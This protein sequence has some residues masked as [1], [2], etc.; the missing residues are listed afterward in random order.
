MDNEGDCLKNFGRWIT[1]TMFDSGKNGWEGNALRL[2]NSDL[3]EMFR[4]TLK[5]GNKDVKHLCLDYF[6]EEFAEC[7]TLVADAE[8]LHQEEVGWE[9]SVK[10]KNT[11]GVSEVITEGGAPDE[12]HLMWYA[13]MSSFTPFLLLLLLLSTFS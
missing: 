4:W 13:S 9:F 1:I 2:L 10:A 11:D 3:K 12:A 8:G 7:Y 5:N 6:G